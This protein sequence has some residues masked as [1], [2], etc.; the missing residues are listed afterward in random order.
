MTEIVFTATA[1]TKTYI[2]GETQVLAL[3]GLD[4]EVF[5]GEVVVLLGPSGSGKSTLLNIM[6]GLDHATSGQL[7]FRGQELT[8]L[9]D[10]GLTDYRRQHVG[11]VFQFYN[12]IPS[13]TAYEN[14]AL[15][16]EIS[17]HPMRPDEAL[18]LVGLEERMHHFPAQLSGGEQQRVAIA[19]AIAKRPDV[20]FCDEPTGALD[21]KTGIR[22]IEALL[23]VNAQLGTTVLII[24][25]NA[26]IQD[27]ADRVL[28]FADG[29]ISRIHKNETRRTAA[30]LV[31]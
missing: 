15:V 14:V 2:T 8:G 6:G 21:S 19:R 1:L 16:T 7:F 13:L 25:H 11:F 9:D 22:V 23:G 4:L 26:S 18:A 5:A 31:W 28:F 17:D 20:L 10:R 12:L 3:R 24:T 29:Q 27:V 30:E